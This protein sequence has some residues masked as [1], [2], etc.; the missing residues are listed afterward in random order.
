VNTI[1]TSF[2]GMDLRSY[3]SQRESDR[4]TFAQLVLPV[5]GE[6]QLEIDGREGRLDPFHG[7]LVAAGAWHSQCSTVANRS[8]ILDIDQAAMTGGVWNRLLERPSIPISPAAGKLLD[9]MQLA[10]GQ[11]ALQP[12]LIRAWIPL[13]LDTL[14]LDA[15]QMRT[16]LTA[17]LAQVE[18]NPGL[19]WTT[20]SMAQFAHVSVSRLHALY[21]EELDISPHAWL[22]QKRIALACDYLARTGRGVADIALSTGFSD[23]TALTRAMRQHIDITPAAYRRR[24]QENKSK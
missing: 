4:H 12:T 6:V 10:I 1:D 3:P 11:Q 13:L 2:I 18:A 21:R 16:R 7:A 17:L 24:S 8:L 9:Y 14:V 22:L 23:Q 20:E 5:T 19:P 15:P